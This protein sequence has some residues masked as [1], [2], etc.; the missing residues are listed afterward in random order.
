M[1]SSCMKRLK[2]L[3]KLQRRNFCLNAQKDA[4]LIKYKQEFWFLNAVYF[5][6]KTK[7]F[8]EDQGSAKLKPEDQSSCKRLPDIFA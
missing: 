5:N 2:R 1:L 3:F 7:T 4:T 6:M 8:L